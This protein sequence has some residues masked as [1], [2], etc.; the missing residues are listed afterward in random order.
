MSVGTTRSLCQLSR[1]HEVALDFLC[2]AGLSKI[3]QKKS[4]SVL[5]EEWDLFI[6]Q[7]RLQDIMEMVN[8]SSVSR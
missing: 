3:G 2:S 7:E 5:Y 8:R 6:I 1:Q 4:F